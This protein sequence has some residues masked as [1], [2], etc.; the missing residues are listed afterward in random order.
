MGTQADTASTLGHF[1][2]SGPSATIFAITDN[3]ANAVLQGWLLN[4]DDNY[5]QDER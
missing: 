2:V 3:R 4:V 1:G 5:T